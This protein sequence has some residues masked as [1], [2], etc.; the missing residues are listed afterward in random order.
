MKC[1]RSKVSQTR[2]DLI[3]NLKCQGT[4]LLSPFW[5][6]DLHGFESGACEFLGVSS[7]QSYLTH[8]IKI[9]RSLSESDLDSGS[10][11]VFIGE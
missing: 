5:W 11:Q 1:V 3:W 4:S 2:P 7:A 10:R 8:N 9:F 6:R